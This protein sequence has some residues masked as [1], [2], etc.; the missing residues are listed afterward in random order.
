MSN[1][2][3]FPALPLAEWT[4]TKET[5]HRYL[6]IVGKL[7]LSLMPKN[8]HWWHITLYVTNTGIATG[9]IPNK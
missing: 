1:H 5:L 8:N 9:A 7:R 3:L 6:Q 2:T 4:K